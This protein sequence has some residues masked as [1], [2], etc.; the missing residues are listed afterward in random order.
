MNKRQIDKNFYN[1]YPEGYK[2]FA[3]DLIKKIGKCEFEDGTCKGLLTTAH[4]DQ[5]PQNNDPDNIKVLCRSHHIRHDQPFHVFSKVS[6]SKK[7]DNSYREQKSLLREESV[8]LIRKKEINVLEM[9][10]GSGVLWDYVKKNSNKK[11]NILKIEVKDNKKGV[12]LKGDNK[13]FY[14]L[15]NF[16]NYDIIDIDAYGIPYQQLKAIFKKEYKGIVIVTFIQSVMGRLPN[17]LLEDIGYTKTMIDKCPTLFSKNGL[18]KLEIYLFQNGVNQI[19]GY[20]LGRKNY[21]YFK[22]NKEA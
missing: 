21:F 5:D 3:K 20:F 18:D 16:E 2:Q 7:T 8:K 12:Y 22:L 13:K 10:A 9:Y 4:L 17:G 15:F 11:I 1:I 6:N 14:P 19:T